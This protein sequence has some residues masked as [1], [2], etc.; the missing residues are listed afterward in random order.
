MI[1]ASI[2]KHI[3]HPLPTTK[4]TSK[5]TLNQPTKMHPGHQP[6]NCG[7]H[8]HTLFKDYFISNMTKKTTWT[9]IWDR[10]NDQVKRDF[11]RE[12]FFRVFER[13]YCN[14]SQR[15]EETKKKHYSN[16]SEEHLVTMLTFLDIEAG[17]HSKI[18]ESIIRLKKNTCQK[19]KKPPPN[20]QAMSPR[21]TKKSRLPLSA[22]VALPM[23]KCNHDRIIA[24]LFNPCPILVN[25]LTEQA[26]FSPD[27]RSLFELLDAPFDE[28]LQQLMDHE[29]LSLGSRASR[30]ASPIRAIDT[31]SVVSKMA[32]GQRR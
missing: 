31:S 11:E 16:W 26:V 18:I 28:D 5:Q 23:D 10:A 25:S 17:L 12:K 22:P 27:E 9:V 3:P 15:F 14:W 6:E 32:G 30:S 7:C 19:R 24:K 8:Y 2:D 1:P 13:F 4:T 21:V 20:G 29:N